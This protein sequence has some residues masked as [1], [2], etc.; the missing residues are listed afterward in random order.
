MP[1][2]MIPPVPL[3]MI[4][5][6]RW[7]WSRVRL[8]LMMVGLGVLLGSFA[9][10]AEATTWYLVEEARQGQ[11]QQYV[12]LDSV[13][14]LGHSIQVRSLY[15][16]RP[17]DP[18]DPTTAAT[19]VLYLTEYDCQHRLFRDMQRNGQPLEPQ[20]FGVEGDPLN[21]ATLDYVCALPEGLRSGQ[22]P[23]PRS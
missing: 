21:G 7:G 11:Q 13:V 18:P 17:A 1:R 10:P 9:L 23:S 6:W 20:W 8:G 19:E 15:I 4:P 12:D 2:W 5:G 22:S 16:S 3:V 14:P